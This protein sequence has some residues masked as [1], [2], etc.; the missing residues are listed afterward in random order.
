MFHYSLANGIVTSIIFFIWNN[1]CSAMGG[2][3]TGKTGGGDPHT[4]KPLKYITLGLSIFAECR[5]TELSV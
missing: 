1:K 4:Q 2:H 3:V 5:N